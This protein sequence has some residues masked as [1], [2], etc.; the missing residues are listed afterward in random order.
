MTHQVVCINLLNVPN[1]QPPKSNHHPPKKSTPSRLY[2]LC[3]YARHNLRRRLSFS[4]LGTLDGDCAPV[5]NAPTTGVHG[6]I[7]NAERIS[8]QYGESDTATVSSLPRETGSILCLV[9]AQ[10]LRH[11]QANMEYR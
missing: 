2:R 10:T 6:R 4:T 9:S 7:V 3:L 11:K 8:R 5:E 1:H